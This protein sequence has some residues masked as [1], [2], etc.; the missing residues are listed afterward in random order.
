MRSGF[1]P[2]EFV[3]SPVNSMMNVL[4]GG[5][6]PASSSR[7]KKHLGYESMQVW[8]LP[9]EL[10]IKGGNDLGVL[11]TITYPK[12]SVLETRKPSS[13]AAAR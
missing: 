6:A 13:T 5:K 2:C 1:Q 8:L 3:P 9:V 4:P 10:H 7:H 12:V 11:L